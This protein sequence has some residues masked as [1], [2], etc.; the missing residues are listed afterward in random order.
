MTLQSALWLNTNMARYS[1]LNDLIDLYAAL[2]ADHGT[3]LDQRKRRD[4]RIGT[5]LKNEKVRPAKQIRAWLD[6]VAIPSWSRNDRAGT[7]LYHLLGFI[8]A[9]LGA[10]SGWGMAQAA[11]H[12]TGD[13]PINIVGALMVLILPQLILLLF[14]LLAAFPWRLP[15][16]RGLQ[17]TLRFLHPGRLTR[18]VVQRF[19]GPA[20]RQLQIVWDP[21]NAIV[22]A[23]AARWLFSFWSQLFAFAFNVGVLLAVL[24]LITFSDLAFA[25]STTLTLDTETFHRLVAGLSW[26]WH[27]VVPAAVPSSELVEASRYFRLES[28]AFGVNPDAQ[29]AAMLG[30]WWPFLVAAVVCYGLLPRLLTLLISWQRF[31]AHLR[32][33]LPR[34]PGAPELLARMNSPLVSTAALQPESTALSDGGGDA[35]T[36]E[37][38]SG[39]MTRCALIAWSGSVPDPE[40][41]ARRLPD[42]GI[43]AAGWQ[44]AG[45]ALSTGQDATTV[46]AVCK[47]RNEGVAVVA[48][49]WEPPLLDFVDFLRSLRD[50]CS[51]HQP[52][53][54]LLW[55]GGEAVSKTDAEV[56]YQTLRQLKD[57]DL[58]IEALS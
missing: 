1:L 17:S 49:A 43:E 46:A 20:E 44:H 55:G 6:R 23:S 58:H 52:I 11:L 31:Y 40:A 36:L 38:A 9:L 50:Q 39:A 10:L 45:G 14:W 15:L 18:L 19:P 8:L 33:A 41:I 2:R 22:L 12:Y 54:V 30:S 34:L 24:Y 51:H 7:K 48:K 21:E 56:W 25:W 29:R 13:A 4:R 37:L 16:V 42:L 32:R 3:E 57:P 5:A 26:P 53:V 28:G 27:G 47:E 35:Y